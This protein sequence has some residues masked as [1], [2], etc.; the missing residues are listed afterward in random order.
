M[1]FDIPQEV[2][3]NCIECE[4]YPDICKGQWISE[5]CKEDCKKLKKGEMS[6]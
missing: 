3:Q 4:N 5:W 2:D 1:A 6:R